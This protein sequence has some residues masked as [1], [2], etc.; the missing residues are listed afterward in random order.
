MEPNVLEEILKLKSLRLRRSDVAR[1]LGIPVSTLK[2]YTQEGLFK[3]A[4]TTEGGMTLYDLREVVIR[5]FEI[6]R[7]KK[8]GKSLAEIKSVILN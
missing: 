5:H 1:T 4:E 8:E 6:E 2:F 7:L 3:V